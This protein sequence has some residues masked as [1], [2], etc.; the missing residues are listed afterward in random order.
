[1]VYPRTRAFGDSQNSQNPPIAKSIARAVERPS[2]A[3]STGEETT[4]AADALFVLIGARPHTDWLPAEIARDGHGFLLTGDELPEDDWRLERRPFS[5]ETSMPGV[6]AAGDVRRAS[7]KR[8]A[9]AV[10]EGSIAIQLVQRLF[11]FEQLHLGPRH[12]LPARR[13][14]LRG[15]T[16]RR[17]PPS[18]RAGRPRG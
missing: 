2:A 11:A 14:R 13:P 6:L 12:S 15:R 4:V 8:V 16:A 5:H 7:V 10:G 18:P 9:S 17:R 1:M 3:S